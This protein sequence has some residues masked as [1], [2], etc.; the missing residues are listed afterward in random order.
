MKLW[1][2]SLLM[3][4]A[5]VLITVGAAASYV[6][7]VSKSTVNALKTTYTD[8]GNKDTAKV[9]KATEPLTI[10][11]LGVDT[12]GV[13]R[14][15]SDD[16]NGNSD[17]QI[18]MTLNPKTNTTTM[19][20]MER[21]TMTNILDTDGNVVST[22]KMNA[23]Y[24]MGFN[25][26]GTSKG[27]ETAVGYS[28]KT[29]GEQAGVEVDNFVTINFDGL[30]NLVDA[31]GGVDIYNDPKLIAASTSTYPNPN[32]EIF[33]SDTEPQYTARVAS[34][35]QHINGEQA[36]V[37][38]RDRHHRVGGDY[39]RQVA[40]RQVISALMKKLLALDNLTQYQKILDEASKDFKTNIPITTS[41]LSY[42][43]GYKDCFKK[44]VSIQYQGL[45]ETVNGGSYQ[46]IPTNMYLGIQNVMRQS[47]GQSSVTT[48]PS[49]L[50]TY[51]TYFSGSTPGYEMPSATVTE[52]GK[53]TSYGIDKTGTL[54]AITDANASQY[55]SINLGSTVSQSSTS[56]SSTSSSSS[57]ASTTS[58]TTTSSSAST[59]TE[60]SVPSGL[61][62]TGTT[63][64][65]KSPNG[66]DV[67]Y[68]NGYY[69]YNS[70]KLYPDGTKYPGQ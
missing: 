54:V 21:D 41:T 23:A 63:G 14:G 68:K 64:V 39:G 26:G 33:I 57:T 44:V 56:T 18:V 15:T 53:Q 60:S 6:Y 12:G 16:W 22:Q 52:N 24:P 48:L 35:W 47:L 34:G 20:S 40:Q 17:S 46:F 31:V 32:H 55:T 3:T 4:G 29:I 13:G 58:G 38:T 37:Y 67:Y 59:T 49:H 5:I 2:K 28:M 61:T 8:V 43:L 7:A 70:G 66:Y 65:Y 27:L 51:E 69:V 45:G 1:M 11:L 25:A 50:I 10:V 42:L 36:L 62:A 19:V 9:L 30:I